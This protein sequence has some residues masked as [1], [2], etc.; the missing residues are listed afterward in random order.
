MKAHLWRQVG[1][2]PPSGFPFIPLDWLEVHLPPTP[3][4]HQERVIICSSISLVGSGW[5]PEH[6]AQP[7]AHSRCPWHHPGPDHWGRPGPS[8]KDS[9]RSRPCSVFAGCGARGRA[10]RRVD[11]G[12][13]LITIYFI[14]LQKNSCC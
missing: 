11:L 13:V 12:P 3:A 9:G 14:T 2:L 6:L 7:L 10:A 8:R 1:P 5:H 4:H